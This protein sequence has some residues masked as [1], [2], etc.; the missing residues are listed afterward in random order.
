MPGLPDWASMAGLLAR[1]CSM[2]HGLVHRAE[3][4]LELREEFRHH[5]AERADDLMREGLTPDAAERS[6][7]GGRQG[8]FPS[9]P[10]TNAFTNACATVELIRS[11]VPRLKRALSWSLLVS[12]TNVSPRLGSLMMSD[13]FPIQ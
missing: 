13:E 12:A 2:Y 9:D 10:V 4:E 6:H 7:S 3:V 8:S 1:A 11:P 5:L